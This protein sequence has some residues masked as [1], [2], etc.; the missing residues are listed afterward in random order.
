MANHMTAAT[1]ERLMDAEKNKPAV[2]GPSIDER[3]RRCKINGN[4]ETMR[5]CNNCWA[6]LQDELKKKYGVSTRKVCVDQH[7]IK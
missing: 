7:E 3:P 2:T 4:V 5:G 6:A 1:I